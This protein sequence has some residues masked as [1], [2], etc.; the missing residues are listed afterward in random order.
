M[1]M[2][3][4]KTVLLVSIAAIWVVGIVT[5]TELFA[6][7]VKFYVQPVPGILAVPVLPDAEVIYI[8]VFAGL[9]KFCINANQKSV[10]S[11]LYWAKTDTVVINTNAKKMLSF[12]II[13]SCNNLLS[14]YILFF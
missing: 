2:P 11:V 7:I 10:P 12:L 1:C 5:K 13:V 8:N 6:A 14:K 4:F 9:S 3:L